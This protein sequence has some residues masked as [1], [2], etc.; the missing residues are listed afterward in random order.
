MVQN[1]FFDKIN[2]LGQPKLAL[3]RIASV[4]IPLPP[5]AE[6]KRIVEKCDRLMSL[7][8]TLEAKLKQGRGN[9]EKLMEVAAK[10]VLAS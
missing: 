4:L 7:C 6:Q 5:L 2:Q 8:D 10:Q 1:Q 9:S 3:K